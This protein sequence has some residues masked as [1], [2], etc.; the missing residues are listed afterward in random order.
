MSL[1]TDRQRG[2]YERTGGRDVNVAK[3]DQRRLWG[4]LFSLIALSGG[5]AVLLRTE[6]SWTAVQSRYLQEGGPRHA[7]I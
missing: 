6:P 2:Q 5:L 7:R 3:R 1:P 4:D